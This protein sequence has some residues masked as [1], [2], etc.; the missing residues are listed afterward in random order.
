ML[1]SDDFRKR[2][3]ARLDSIKNHL[4]TSPR[5]SRLKDKVC[6]ITGAGSLKGIGYAV[7]SLLCIIT[8]LTASPRRA[9]ALLYAHEGQCSHTSAR[10]ARNLI[11]CLPRGPTP[12]PERL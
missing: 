10:P 9:S 4:Q 8:G 12:L 1:A 6:V 7:L 3:L 2:T 5:G 11:C